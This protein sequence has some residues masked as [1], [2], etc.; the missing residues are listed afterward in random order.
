MS[1]GLIVFM[2]GVM[3]LQYQPVAPMFREATNTA[4]RAAYMQSGTDKLVDRFTV[5]SEKKAARTARE[6]GIPEPMFAGMI[7]TAKVIRDKRIDVHGPK[8]IY[9]KTY[10]TVS[11]DNGIV[12]IG[13]NF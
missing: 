12:S 7:T 13:W 3:S 1:D 4:S 9:G 10:L 2:V 11:P 6:S 5:Y 8:I